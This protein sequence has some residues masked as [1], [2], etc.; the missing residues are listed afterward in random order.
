MGPDESNPVDLEPSRLPD[1]SQRNEVLASPST[2]ED[3][4]GVIRI[5]RAMHTGT[6]ILLNPTDAIEA[7]VKSEDGLPPL[8]M[9]AMADAAIPKNHPYSGQLRVTLIEKA[10]ENEAKNNPEQLEVTNA[11]IAF[12]RNRLI[13][14]LLESP[15]SL[16]NFLSPHD[17]VAIINVGPFRGDLQ[18][19]QKFLSGIDTAKYPVKAQG[20]IDDYSAI[21]L[22]HELQHSKD[23]ANWSTSFSS[24]L[25]PKS[26][27]KKEVSA[28]CGG[29][30]MAREFN[31]QGTGGVNPEALKD[32]ASYR[33]LK[34]FHSYDFDHATSFWL[35]ENPS[36]RREVTAQEAINAKESLQNFHRKI[37]EEIGRS[38]AA[39][40]LEQWKG[41]SQN[42]SSLPK[43]AEENGIGFFLDDLHKTRDAEYFEKSLPAALV[44][45]DPEILRSLGEKLKKTDDGLVH[46]AVTALDSKGD[47]PDEYIRT[48]IDRYKAAIERVCPELA[49]SE[50]SQKVL[51]ASLQGDDLSS[52]LEP[53]KEERRKLLEVPEESLKHSPFWEEMNGL[54]ERAQAKEPVESGPSPEDNQPSSAPPSPQKPSPVTLGR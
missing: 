35:D 36:C 48:Y 39:Q 10:F 40:T 28:D 38:F 8:P 23:F 24:L 15:S 2:W 49:K 41:F 32:D 46:G 19:Y 45:S 1:G 14:R 29:Y 9:T 30:D 25:E 4:G 22:L 52:L 51:A 17:N 5:L 44:G 26:V 20:T 34:A 7:G 50:A 18:E 13:E 16:P 3:Y 53:A 6:I 27:L 33:A 43:T 42:A 21:D 11:Q 37:D 47:I 54:A 31:R 12:Y